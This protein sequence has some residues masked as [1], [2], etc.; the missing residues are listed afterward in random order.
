MGEEFSSF[1]L[2]FFTYGSFPAEVNLSW[3]VLTPKC[4]NLVEVLD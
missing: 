3:V 1:V 4:D 2:E